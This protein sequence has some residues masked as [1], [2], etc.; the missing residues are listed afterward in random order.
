MTRSESLKGVAHSTTP[1]AKPQG[2]PPRR[3]INHLI[4]RGCLVSR[5]G[6]AFY[7]LRPSVRISISFAIRAVRDTPDAE[8]LRLAFTLEQT[9]SQRKTDGTI[10]VAGVRFELPSRFRTLGRVTVRYR[11]WD[12][13]SAW[14]IDPRTKVVLA[15]I[16]PLD[17]QANADGRRRTLAPLP[18]EPE[19]VK[20]AG[21]GDPMPPLMRKLLADYA[22][23]GLPPA[24]LPKDELPYTIEEDDDA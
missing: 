2:V 4:V 14:V 8:R 20:S 7:S 12:L 24:Y 16:R 17:K 5:V 22:A 23:T 10:S 19:V 6:G 3:E 1:F 18:D 9:R 13:S 21:L 11:R 15:R